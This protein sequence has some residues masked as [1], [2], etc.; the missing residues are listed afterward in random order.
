[1]EKTS[2]G[3]IFIE[4]TPDGSSIRLYLMPGIIFQEEG[5]KILILLEEISNV[6]Q[7]IRKEV[8][9]PILGKLQAKQEEKY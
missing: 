7:V 6:K 8:I 3:N 2:S 9:T 1:M 4:G 5:V